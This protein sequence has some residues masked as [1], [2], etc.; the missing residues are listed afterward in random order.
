[1]YCSFLRFRALDIGHEG[2]PQRTDLVGYECALDVAQLTDC[3]SIRLPSHGKELAV[4]VTIGV[5][6][7]DERA[8]N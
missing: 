3:R 1:M 2:P 6:R 4:P 7:C 8:I 5:R